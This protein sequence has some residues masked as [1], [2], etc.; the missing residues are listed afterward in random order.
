MLQKLAPVPK[1]TPKWQLSRVESK[2]CFAPVLPSGQPC[3]VMWNSRAINRHPC[4]LAAV[5]MELVCG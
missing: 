1:K 5:Q 2:V 4:G 3:A